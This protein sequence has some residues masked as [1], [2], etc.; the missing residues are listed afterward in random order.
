MMVILETEAEQQQEHRQERD[1]RD[2]IEERH[3][4]IEL[5]G[6]PGHLRAEPDDDAGHGAEREP[7][8]DAVEARGKA[9][10]S[11]PV[12]ASPQRG[13]DRARPGQVARSMPARPKTLQAT[14]A[15]S[16]SIQCWSDAELIFTL[17]PAPAP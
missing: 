7:G 1:L 13:E 15:A 16:G 6:I 12:T 11:S 2:G 3:Q 17:P 10:K 5:F 14:S 9:T 8:R 4:R